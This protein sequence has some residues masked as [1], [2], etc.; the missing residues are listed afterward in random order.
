MPTQPITTTLAELNTCD[1]GRFVEL[2]GHLY[3]SSPW[4]A[5]ETFPRRPFRDAPHL[6]AELSATLAGSSNQRQLMLICSHP[7]LAG[8]KTFSGGLSAASAAEQESAGLTAMESE[9][10][11]SFTALNGWYRL[12]FGFPFVIC[13]RLNDKDSILAAMKARL[14]NS[15]EDELATALAE[16]G[17][18]ARLRLEAVLQG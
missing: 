9:E 17:K 18:I 16:I 8:V 2:L 11:A 14:Q 5:E 1:Q 3:E 6:L 12:R 4:V 15:R 7:D 10:I 13:A